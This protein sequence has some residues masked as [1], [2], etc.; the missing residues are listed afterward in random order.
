MEPG[1]CLPGRFPHIIHHFP[2]LSLLNNDVSADVNSIA[3]SA[4]IVKF[5]LY[6]FE[7]V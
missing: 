7:K 5:C 4:A 6:I 2:A 1:E 3:E